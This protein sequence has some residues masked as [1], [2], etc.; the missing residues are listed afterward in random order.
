MKKLIVSSLER[1]VG[2]T[3]LILGLAGSYPGKFAY[4]KPFGDRLVYHEKKL[5]DHDAQLM[6][7]L[8]DLQHSPAEMSLGFDHSKIKFQ[9][10]H[11]TIQT[12]LKAMAEKYQQSNDLLI[13]ETGRDLA[14]G[15]AL[16]LDALS[17]CKSMGGTQVLVVGGIHDRIMDDLLFF[18]RHLYLQD[19]NFAGVI[20]NKVK[21]IPEF[22]KEFHKELDSLKFP[23]LGIIPYA[24]ELSSPTVRNIAETLSAKV[25]TA[26]TNLDVDVREILVG[27]MSADAVL[28]LEKF[29]HREK[30]IITS[31]DRSDMILA[32][33]NA[34]CVG[35]VLTNNILPPPNI[36]AL[37]SEKNVP[38]MIVQNDTFQIAKKIDMMVP[39]INAENPD[40]IDLIKKLVKENVKTELLWA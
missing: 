39:L 20:L 32:A 25:L 10:D 9:Y 11:S 2:K 27:A 19:H 13:V 34:E 12:T 3:S 16:H 33:I 17:I 37:V 18:D 4:L 22:L 28:R 8:F 38:L 7:S 23:I 5:W 1:D 6:G 40:K 24:A 14:R 26:E 21:D 35:I 31:G 15:T 29:K 36:I 30:L